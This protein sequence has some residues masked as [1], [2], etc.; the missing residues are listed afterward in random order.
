M[1]T[2]LEQWLN[3]LLLELRDAKFYGKLV[4]EM[5]A[6]KVHLLRKE[7]TLKPP[8]EDPKRD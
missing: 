3:S 1:D 6:G 4:I 5:R 8:A 7:E 2:P